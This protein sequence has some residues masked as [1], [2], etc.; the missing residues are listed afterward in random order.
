MCE[1]PSVRAEPGDDR[2]DVGPHALG[3]RLVD[4][5]PELEVLA[6]LRHAGRA[7]EVVEG[8]RRVAVLGQPQGELLVERVEAPD[9]RQDHHRLGRRRT[10]VRVGREGREAVAV[11]GLED[12]VAV[13]DRG[14]L[15]RRD[16]RER[17]V[18][19]AHG[20]RPYRL[21][22]AR[23]R[24]RPVAGLGHHRGCAPLPSPAVVAPP[25][26]LP[27]PDG[28]CTSAPSCSAAAIIASVTLRGWWQ[29]A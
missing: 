9:V 3:G 14:P 25:S 7:A 17:V 23:L 24:R 5:L 29:A 6:A 27:V 1:P 21:S 20:A 12:E 15:Q 26:T 19:E 11:G 16:W 10:A 4:V 28:S 13:I 8:H 2:G 22:A 18:V